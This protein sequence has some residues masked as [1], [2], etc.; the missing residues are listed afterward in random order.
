M[1]SC[2]GRIFGI[3]RPGDRASDISANSKKQIVSYE[4]KGDAMLFEHL[5]MYGF[6]NEAPH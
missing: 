5:M 1:A 4:M 2:L 6:W 3:N